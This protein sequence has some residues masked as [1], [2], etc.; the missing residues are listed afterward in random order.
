MN[1]ER[2]LRTALLL[3]LAL[4]PA[5]AAQ[6]QGTFL[7]ALKASRPVLELRYRY[8]NVADDALPGRPA[9]A[10]TLRTVLGLET[11]VWHGLS[12]RLDAEDVSVV[13]SDLYNNA[14]AAGSGNGVTD[15]PVVADPDGT[16]IH[17][18][19]LRWQG[20]R[21]DLR[22]GRQEVVLGHARFIGNVG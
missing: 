14:G 22:I 17:Q 10:S 18:A 16:A 13:G 9:R 1:P 3:A 15:R 8:E 7:D 19:Y 12:L 4:A 11:G 2:N 20:Q 21:A 5:A 6:Q